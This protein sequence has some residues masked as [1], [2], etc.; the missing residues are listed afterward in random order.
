MIDLGWKSDELIFMA[1]G[2]PPFLLAYGSGK[3]ESVQSASRTDMVLAAVKQQGEGVVLNAG[4]GKKI[5][6]GGEAALEPPAPPKPWKTWLLWGVL[7]VGVLLMA[8]MAMSLMKDMQKATGE[9]DD[10]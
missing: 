1:R 4:L 3:I 7:I 5:Q 6:L 2:T 9:T 8:I 10:E